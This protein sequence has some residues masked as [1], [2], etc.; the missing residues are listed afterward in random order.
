MT[1]QPETG[2]NL[3]ACP[4]PLTVALL[5]VAW[6]DRTIR[7]R[8]CTPCAIRA[9]RTVDELELELAAKLGR[10]KITAR[11]L[12]RDGELRARSGRYIPAPG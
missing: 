12:V 7:V 8:V 9:W 2:C 10:L 3:C 1:E 5:R 11:R 4:G 6:E